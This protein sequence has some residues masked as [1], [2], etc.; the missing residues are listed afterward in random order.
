VDGGGWHADYRAIQHGFPREVRLRSDDGRV[1]LLAAVQQLEVNGAIDAAA[2]E[3][4]IPPDA[5]PM[6][7]DELRSVAP[8]R[9]P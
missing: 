6:T 8:L 2:F 9:T 5:D 4:S 1:D 3:V 7:L